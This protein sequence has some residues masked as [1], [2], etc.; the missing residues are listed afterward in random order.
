VRPN[1][2]I[3]NVIVEYVT[4]AHMTLAESLVYFDDLASFCQGAA[5]SVLKEMADDAEYER[6]DPLDALVGELL[7]RG[8]EWYAWARRKVTGR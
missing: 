2:T 6:G 4:I 3:E 8:L 1:E 7:G 5:E